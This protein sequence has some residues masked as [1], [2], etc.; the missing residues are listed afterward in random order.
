[1]A[2][3]EGFIAKVDGRPVADHE[4]GVVPPVAA[5]VVL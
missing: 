3:V 4:N 1:M 5:T 2:P